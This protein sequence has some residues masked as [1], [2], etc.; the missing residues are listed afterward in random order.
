MDPCG[1]EGCKF[2]L[3]TTYFDCETLCNKTAGCT[4]YV[5]SSASCDAPASNNV[6]AWGA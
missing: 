5:F 2:D 1:S 4:A 6:S 3:K